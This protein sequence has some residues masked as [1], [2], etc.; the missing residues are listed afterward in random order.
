MSI[1][2]TTI[3]QV[4]LP[5]ASS[6]IGDGHIRLYT[7]D[8]GIVLGDHQDFEVYS[9]DAIDREYSGPVSTAKICNGLPYLRLD[10]P[11]EIAADGAAGFTVTL[12]DN[13]RETLAAPEDAPV[14]L[15][16]HAG[17]LPQRKIIIPAGE[18]QAEFSFYADRLPAGAAV[19][20]KAGFRYY[21]AAATTTVKIV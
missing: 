15:D 18:S 6:S 2:E 14:Y 13:A 8:H 12:I 5:W 4:R 20:L 19:E 1:T 17:Y 10:G 16:A 11:A 21:P 3:V 7:G 9:G